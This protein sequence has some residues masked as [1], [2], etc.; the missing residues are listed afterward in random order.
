[1]TSLKP[2]APF[3]LC[4]FF[5]CTTSTTITTSTDASGID[6][7]QSE[8][9]ALGDDGA[10]EAGADAGSEVSSDF[11]AGKG[12]WGQPCT[13]GNDTTC[14]SGLFCLQG[15]AGG[16]VGFCT[17]TCPSTSSAAC[18]NTPT[19]TAAYCVV[20]DA[21]SNGDKGCAFACREGATNYTCPGQLKCETTADPPGSGQYLCLP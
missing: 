20:T 17:K 1:V 18:P 13:V 9:A 12:S 14:T 3:A 11:D 8:A 16:T 15:P 2:F 4:G 7:P 19:G 21:D 5:G 10:P 6:A